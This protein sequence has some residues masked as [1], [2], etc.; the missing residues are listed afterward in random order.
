MNES[1][2]ISNSLIWNKMQ[3][4]DTKLACVKQDFKTCQ[5][6]YN[7]MYKS[8]FERNDFKTDFVG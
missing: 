3:N 8:D 4:D 2:T 5:Q 7:A 6:R 1:H